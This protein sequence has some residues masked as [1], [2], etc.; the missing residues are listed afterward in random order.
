[1]R[2]EDALEE[3]LKR[4]KK[5]YPLNPD[6]RNMSLWSILTA[7]RGPD[8]TTLTVQKN[9]GKVVITMDPDKLKELTTSRIRSI[10]GL[11]HNGLAVKVGIRSKPL[12]DEEIAHRNRLMNRFD[13]HFATHFIA[14]M[15]EL[16]G[17]GY[18]VPDKELDFAT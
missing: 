3:L 17:L 2:F 16:K 6:A 14:A 18:D 15:K 11:D 9:A 10:I 13:K 5:K 12:T 4:A 8:Q 7:L 1:M